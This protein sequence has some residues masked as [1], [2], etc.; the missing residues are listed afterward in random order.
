MDENTQ[1]Q[2]NNTGRTNVSTQIR[3]LY[4]PEM[5]CITIKFYN[6]D[7]SFSL[8]PFS[9]KTAS[10]F[11]QY[12]RDKSIWANLKYD[13]VS[14]LYQL[15]SDVLGGRVDGDGAQ[16]STI[17]NLRN[18]GTVNII[19][20]WNRNQGTTLTMSRNNEAIPFKFATDKINV[21]K[22][23]QIT[24][25]IV[26]T[27]LI[28]FANTLNG[29]LTGINADLH[30]NKMKEEYVK[31]QEANPQGGYQ[32]KGNYRGG[33][34]R[35]NFQR[36]NFNNQNQGGSYQPKAQQTTAPWSTDQMNQ[37]VNLDSYNVPG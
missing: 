36:R 24:Q 15:V 25:R 16:V 23:G 10:G 6:M 5:S 9:G 3:T 1:Q 30:L 37:A 18:V 21:R 32:Q 2:G 35:G 27:G 8:S 17:V 29:Y 26:D 7:L 28:T 34:N 31:Q 12:N 22:D 14:L 11:D 4:S 20:E 19:L 13:Q 33:N